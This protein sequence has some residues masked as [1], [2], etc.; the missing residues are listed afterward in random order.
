MYEMLQ[1]LAWANWKTMSQKQAELRKYN[2]K[3]TWTW[4]ANSGLCE[5]MHARQNKLRLILLVYTK[6]NINYRMVRKCLLMVDVTYSF[7]AS[8]VVH[9]QSILGLHIQVTEAMLQVFTLH[10]KSTVEKHQSLKFILTSQQASGC[11]RNLALKHGIHGTQNCS[12]KPWKTPLWRVAL[13]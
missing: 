9:E 7:E 4:Q 1:R 12:W 11:A 3:I 2:S 10:V 5:H 13:L 8:L 6:G